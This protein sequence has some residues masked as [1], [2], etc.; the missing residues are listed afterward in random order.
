M[1]EYIP[2]DYFKPNYEGTAQW[3]YSNYKGFDPEV[4][5]MLEMMGKGTLCDE[6]VEYLRREVQQRNDAMKEA[7]ERGGCK[8]Y[9]EEVVDFE[10]IDY[11]PL[12]KATNDGAYSARMFGSF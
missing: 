9:D 5:L 3:W 6:G 2:L 8:L 4:C 12:E 10:K 1:E 11:A 7:F